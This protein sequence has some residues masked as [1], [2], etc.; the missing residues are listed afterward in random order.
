MQE[1][2]VRVLQVDPFWDIWSVDL[3]MK[4]N[5]KIYQDGFLYPPVH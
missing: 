2:D 4:A 5:A 1:Q 3:W